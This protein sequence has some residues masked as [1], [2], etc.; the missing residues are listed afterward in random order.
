MFFFILS[1]SS[2]CV[3]KFFKA[4]DWKAHIGRYISDFTSHCDK[5]QEVLSLYIASNSV[6]TTSNVKVLI[7]EVTK[8]NDLV[9][10][11]FKIKSD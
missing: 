4:Q 10:W 8:I 3:A 2:Q 9:P 1:Q 5:L 11:L 6:Y 7:T